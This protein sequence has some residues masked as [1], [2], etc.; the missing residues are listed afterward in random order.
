MTSR[1]L[2]P[3]SSTSTAARSMCEPTTHRF[4]A[5]RR[6]TSASG[7]FADQH[8]VHGAFLGHGGQAQVQRR[9]GLRVDIGQAD[10]LAGA[11]QA[12]GEVDGRRRFAHAPLLI[13]D[14]DLS[15]RMTPGYVGL[16][17][18]AT[19]RHRSRRRAGRL[20]ERDPVRAAGLPRFV[21]PAASIE[22]AT[23]AGSGRLRQQ[24]GA[25]LH[26][27]RS[28]ARA[29]AGDWRK[30]AAGIRRRRTGV[31]ARGHERESAARSRKRAGI[32]GGSLAAA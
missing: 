7:V 12:G 3:A 30:Q 20:S 28:L 17:S 14:G 15:H 9:V 26:Q 25:F 19:A 4:S 2:T 32:I 8:V 23:A 5:A 1:P 13:D 11:G 24:R 10:A 31:G 27:P 22:A 18:S 16:T 29:A 21:A 6:R